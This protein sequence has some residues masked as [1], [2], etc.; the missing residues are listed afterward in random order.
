VRL[1][2]S[3]W[4]RSLQSRRGDDGSSR[5]GHDS[6]ESSHEDDDP[7]KETTDLAGKVTTTVNSAGE[8]VATTDTT[9]TTMMGKGDGVVPTGQGPALGLTEGEGV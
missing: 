5:E 8:A 4:P 9:K 6:D 1:C 2:R 3:G 7:T